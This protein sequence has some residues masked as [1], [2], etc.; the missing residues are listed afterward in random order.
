LNCSDP[1]KVSIKTETAL[2]LPR[3]WLAPPENLVANVSH[4]VIKLDPGYTSIRCLGDR[5]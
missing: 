5:R 2:G 1:E 4:S 3:E